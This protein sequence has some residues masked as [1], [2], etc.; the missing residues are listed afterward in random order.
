V[1]I[2]IVTQY[3]WPEN[4]RIND[5]ALGLSERGHTVTV[6]TGI[7]NYPEGTFFDGY[8][9]FNRLEDRYEDIRVLRAPLIPRGNGRSLRLFSNYLS[10]VV[11]ASIATYLHRIGKQDVILVYEPSPITVGIPA[12]VNKY[13]HNAPVLFWV[14]DLWPETLEAIGVVKSKRVLGVVEKLVKFIYNRSD[15]ILVQSRAFIESVQKHC[16]NGSIVEY[17]PNSTEEYYQPVVVEGG[18][19]KASL[20]PP[21][22]VVMFAGNIGV[23][24]DF[25]TILNAA[26]LTRHIAEIQWVVIGDGRQKEWLASEIEQRSLGDC[27]HLLGRHPAEQ[28][29][30]FFALADALL[31]TLKRDPIFAL[32][33]PSKVQSYLA[34]ARPV[35]AALDGEG[36]RIIKESGAGL[37]CPAESPQLLAEAVISLH[38]MTADE[39]NMMGQRGRAYFE[40]HFE[41]NMLIDRLEGWMTNVVKEKQG[42]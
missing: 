25:A 11:S 10:F 27:V 34:C 32:T 22:F 23:A 29:P 7:P 2:L 21:G 28:M 37:S 26:E 40:K 8:D 24:Q 17:C 13:M 1:N 35:V 39:R 5:I 36:A 20:L 38:R 16:D 9:A 12:I 14:Q 19:S 6:L 4:F 30:Y 42:P 31:V 3:F 33:I 15:M 41:R 18:F